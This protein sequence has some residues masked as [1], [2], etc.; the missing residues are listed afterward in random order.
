LKSQLQTNWADQSQI[1]L[2][3]EK[4]A[5]ADIPAACKPAVFFYFKEAVKII[6]GI[7]CAKK[8]KCHPVIPA[9]QES[10]FNLWALIFIS[11]IPSRCNLPDTSVNPSRCTA[12][13][14]FVR[15]QLATE[16][17]FDRS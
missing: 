17:S 11:A 10:V 13:L 16:P 5:K 1:R 14:Q 12:N 4:R 2:P 15:M 9:K 3:V 6:H 8:L 7:F